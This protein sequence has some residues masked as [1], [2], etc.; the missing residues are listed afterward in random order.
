M[1]DINLETALA[2]W[3]EGLCVTPTAGGAAKR[4]FASWKEYQGRM[5]TRDEVARW[6]NVSAEN[7]IVTANYQPSTMV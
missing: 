1:T 4:P 2:L 3:K 5:P 7:E 6:G